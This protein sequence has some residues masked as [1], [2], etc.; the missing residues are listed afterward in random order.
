MPFLDASNPLGAGN[1][2][3][4][5]EAAIT[6]LGVTNTTL[7]K[8]GTLVQVKAP[9]TPPSTTGDSNTTTPA[10][11]RG[12]KAATAGNFYG[13][14]VCVG[15]AT[16]GSTPVKNGTLMVLVNGYALVRFKATT[17]AGHVVIVSTS[18]AGNAKTTSAAVLGKSYGVVLK[19][20][21]I[22]SGTKLVPCYIEKF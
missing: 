14:G 8:I 15:G 2:Q 11:L 1:E 13:I 9:Y 21:T 17:T 10:V 4:R 6:T 20:V 19:A 16:L 18:T 12:I 22:T 7:P 3:P 5:Y